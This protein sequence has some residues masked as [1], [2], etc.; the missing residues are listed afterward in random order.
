MTGGN[1]VDPS[2]WRGRRVLVTGHTGFKGGWASLWLNA[3]GAE[4]F[5]LA[6]SPDQTRS[7]FDLVD[8]ARAIDHAVVDLRDA[9]ATRAAVRRA[10]PE[11][12]LH[13]AAQPLVRESVRDPVATFATNVM[14]TAHLLD[15]LREVKGLKAVL[16]VTSDKVYRNDDRGTAFREHDPLGGK[17]PYSG[18]KA[19]AECV[20]YSFRAS[21]FDRLGTPLGVGRGG[22]VIGG[23]DFSADRLVPDLIRAI[24]AGELLVLR[25]PF[26]TRP[27]QHVLDCVA[28][29]LVYLQALARAPEATP[30][31]LNFGPSEAELPTVGALA[32]RLCARLGSGAG[33]RHEPDPASIEMAQ[34]RIDASLAA[35][36]IGFQ[37]RLDAA[38][39]IEL[40]ADWYSAYL[41]GDDV[42]RRLTLQQI[43]RYG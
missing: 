39:A 40:T 4:V 7:L 27:W 36:T 21:F 12:V 16:V 28:G 3:L 41:K 29:Y 18:S 13:L 31:A 32:D 8:V 24:E 10:A 43:E 38:A 35:E 2:F 25:H 26:S 9:E 22:N 30:K 34:L 14:G 15:A 42:L 1:G 6:L 5:G 37:G 11:I 20:A 33:W 19:A 17:D 23:G